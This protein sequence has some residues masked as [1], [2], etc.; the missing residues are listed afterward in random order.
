M[1]GKYNVIVA[2]IVADIIMQ[3]NEEVSNFLKTEAYI[4]QGQYRYI[5][6]IEV[7]VHLK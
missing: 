6:S 4:L 3:F 5:K 7:A 1:S 2:N